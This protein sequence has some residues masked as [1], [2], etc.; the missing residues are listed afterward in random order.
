MGPFT[1]RLPAV[2]WACAAAV[3]A[4]ATIAA[5]A[6]ARDIPAGAD[7]GEH[8]TGWADPESPSFHAKYLAADPADLIERLDDCQQCHGTNYEGGAAGVSCTTAG[9][10]T[11]PGGPE[12]CGTCHGDGTGPRPTTGA[13]GKH[14]AYCSTCHV[15]P[16]NIRDKGHITGHVTVTFSGLALDDGAMPAFDATI[17]TCAGAYCHGTTAQTWRE[18]TTSTPCDTCH[19]NPPASHVGWSRVAQPGACSLCHPVPPTDDTGGLAQ[20]PSA[21]HLNG[22]VNLNAIIA[23][24]TCHGTT[25]DGAPPLSLAGSS[26][27]TVRGVGAHQAHLDPDFPDRMGHVTACAD[28]HTVPTSITQPGHLGTGPDATLTLVGGGS[29]AVGGATC[30]V[31]CHW[32]SSPGPT[33]TD[34]S[35]DA[36]ACDAC[37]GFP[38]VF[39]RTGA[40][41]TAAQPVLSACLM[42]H[43]FSPTT[44]VDGIVELLP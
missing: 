19:G 7:T 27:P 15:V 26:D 18:V 33:W 42:C 43:P 12:W 37:H 23:C 36:I 14:L 29:Y 22:V 38:P 30:V 11:Q 40:V 28:C 25:P 32:N 13:H 9:C 16:T 41:H 6:V 1:P 24:N 34:D 3:A 20:T 10:H 5:C 8:P 21:T 17:L 4:G 31:W 39:T 35:G 2:A 44:H